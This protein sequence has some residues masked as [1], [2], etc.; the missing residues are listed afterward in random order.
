MPLRATLKY[1]TNN[2][3]DLQHASPSSGVLVK[4]DGQKG[5]K[6]FT[7]KHRNSVIGAFVCFALAKILIQLFIRSLTPNVH[8]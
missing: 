4:K 5:T 8:T 6:V 3:V 1:K 2:L 7:R